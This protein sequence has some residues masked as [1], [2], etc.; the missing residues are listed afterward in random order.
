MVHLFLSNCK[1]QNGF[2]FN[3]VVET[4]K[5]SFCALEGPDK[6]VHVLKLWMEKDPEQMTSTAWIAC[7]LLSNVLWNQSINAIADPSRIVSII[8]ARVHEIMLKL[9]QKSTLDVRVLEQAVR[10]IGILA[11][12]GTF[13]CKYLKKRF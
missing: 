8:K 6:I 12:S 9:I 10:F 11:K 3:N 1:I 13:T 5:S 2:Y 4:A 7:I